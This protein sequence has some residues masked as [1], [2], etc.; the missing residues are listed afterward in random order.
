MLTIEPSSEKASAIVTQEKAS[1]RW[2]RYLDW[3]IIG[4]M[5]AAG[6]AGVWLPVD[7]TREL[8]RHEQP[9]WYAGL[10]LGYVLI[11]ALAGWWILRQNES[12]YR[13]RWLVLT[14]LVL[15]PN[16]FNIWVRYSFET[17]PGQA[18]FGRDADIGLYFKYGHDFGTGQPP[19]HNGHPIEY[20]QGALLLFW[21]AERLAGGSQADVRATLNNFFWVFPALMLVFQAGAAA[22][23]Y[24]IGHKVG[25]GRGA[26]WLVAFASGA[27]F[28]YQYNYTR[29]DL[30]PA[31]LLLGAVYFF[32]P[33]PG[34]EGYRVLRPR[35]G[36]TA[37]AGLA[38]GA[39]FLTKW[40]PAV[41]AP[42]LV[43]AYFQT[44]RWR[45]MTLLTASAALLSGLVMLPFYFKDA[46]A[47]WYPYQWQGSR[48]LMG[49]SFWFLVQYHL[50]DP[51][52]SIPSRPWAE[53]EKIVLSNS[54]LQ[55]TQLGLVGLIFGLTL[56]RTWHSTRNARLYDRWAAAGL[57]AVVVF[58]LANR[59]FSPQFMIL[60]V[61]AVAALLVLRPVR[62]PSAVFACGLL[63][64]AGHANFLTFHLGAF[65][66][67]WVRYSLIFFST[68][69]LLSGWLLWHSLRK[70]SDDIVL[71]G[72]K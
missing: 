13:Q 44:R 51:T 46:A 69:W 36:G 8:K 1:K 28:L 26:F 34:A 18:L 39:G 22:A 56:W 29:Y 50:L 52:K 32:L 54:L 30:A 2:A 65:E 57:L 3:L 42:F 62:W 31:A 9:N 72:K 16:L 71:R 41:M 66:E 45:E 12:V 53:P 58:T 5:L 68:A 4:S 20:P 14:A 61:W 35:F 6:L 40:L 24:G 17:E 59:V 67:E 64:L 63:T 25:Q 11:Y 70:T 49:E 27:P 60:I 43:V 38:V 15:L 47:F 19:S 33:D 37:S 7:W 48:Q 10:S 55:A 21:L 23:L